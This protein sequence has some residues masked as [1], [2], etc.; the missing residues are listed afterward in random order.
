MNQKPPE[1]LVSLGIIT[2]I[3]SI[4]LDMPI[5]VTIGIAIATIVIYIGIKLR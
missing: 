1:N 4:I 3:G 5:I 2:V